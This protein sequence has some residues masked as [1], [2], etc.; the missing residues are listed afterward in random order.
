MK[1]TR[2]KLID[3]EWIEFQDDMTEQEIVDYKKSLIPQELTPRQIRLALIQSGVSLSDIDIMIDSI[4]EPQKSIIRT[5]WDYS[6][7]Y[8]RGDDMLI[9]FASQLWMDSEK[10]DNL[11]ILGAT[12]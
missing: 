6:L 12:L 11:F 2:S 8:E 3:W 4:E 10:L 9:Q 7:S 5:L 1:I